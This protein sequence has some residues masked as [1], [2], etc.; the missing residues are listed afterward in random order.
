MQMKVHSLEVDNGHVVEEGKSYWPDCVEISIPRDIALN[1][2]AQLT[3]TLQT[4]GEG[5]IN[6]T[7]M[8]TLDYDTNTDD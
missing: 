8:G 5:K 2:M 6:F 3:A 4:E 1:V 7:L